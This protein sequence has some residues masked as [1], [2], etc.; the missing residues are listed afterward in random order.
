[1][2]AFDRL[3]Y[4]S[5]VTR[6]VQA[7]NEP[8]EVILI[9]FNRGRPPEPDGKTVVYG[10]V[11][12]T[13]SASDANGLLEASGY[14]GIKWW[15]FPATTA[16]P[17]W[18]NTAFP[19]YSGWTGGGEFSISQGQGGRYTGVID[20]RKLGP[21][22]TTSYKLCII[23]MD[24]AGN[25]SKQ[26]VY[27]TFT[28][29]Q[30][31]D[32]PLI[33]ET[34]L[35]PQE[36]GI[37]GR[38][39]LTIKGTV[40][41]LDLFDQTKLNTVYVQIR[42]PSAVNA[43]GVPTAWPAD[44]PANW[45]KV[46]SE[47]LNPSGDI[48]FTLSVDNTLTGSNLAYFNTDGNK[49]YQIKVT[50]EPV[51][52]AKNYGKN[53]DILWQNNPNYPGFVYDAMPAVSKIFPVSADGLKGYS[54]LLDTK[55][56]AIYYNKYDPTEKI[57]LSNDTV[58]NNANYTT[59]R[60]TFT[61]VTDLI[62][63]L[64]G[65]IIEAH[66]STVTIT[67]GAK[68][69]IIPFTGPVNDSVIGSCYNWD[70]KTAANYTE[71]FSDF[72]PSLDG[73]Q[74]IVIEATDVANN[75]SRVSWNFYKDT[76]GPE[77]GFTNIAMS[78][79]K[80]PGAYGAGG[81]A[82]ASLEKPGKVTPLNTN[83]QSVVSGDN[84][85]NLPV[86]KGTFYDALSFVWKVDS[87]GKP[88]ATTFEYRFKNTS[89]VV[90]SSGWLTGQL[91][92]V[93]AATP[94]EPKNS[95]ANWEIVL[96]S[97]HGFTGPDGENWF[98]IRIMDSAGDYLTGTGNW[99]EIYNVRF[100]VDRF[101]P[102]LT[103]SAD[104][105]V[106]GTSIGTNVKLA[107]EKRV[108]AAAGGASDTV[109]FSVSGEVSDINLTNL[110]I[111][112][113]QDSY[114]SGA[115]LPNYYTVTASWERDINLAGTWVV[116][117]P[118][119]KD[120]I[121]DAVNGTPVADT[122]P[123]RLS[124]TPDNA[125][126]PT[127]WTWKLNILEKDIKNLR[128]TA[129]SNAQNSAR[130]YIKVT[131]QDKAKKRPDPAEQVWQFFLDTRKP[132]I[133]YTTLEKGVNGV[134][135]D[136]NGFALSGTVSDDTGIQDVRYM[137]G[138]WDY[139][140]KDWRW[141]NGTGW[142]LNSSSTVVTTPTSWPSISP[143]TPVNTFN[144]NIN[145]DTLTA[146]G[147]GVFPANLFTNPDQEGKYRLDLY[148]RDW[149]LGNANAGNPHNT[150]ASTDATFSDFGYS[151]TGPVQG[152][153]S[154]RVFYIDR[155]DPKLV[156]DPSVNSQTYFRNIGGQ[157]NLG[158]TTGDTNTIQ[159]WEVVIKD[160]IG[161]VILRNGIGM[162]PADVKG[163][164]PDPGIINTLTTD[165][166]LILKPFMTNDGTSGGTALDMVSGSDGLP[167]TYTVTFTVVDGANKSSSVTKQIILDNRPPVFDNFRP[168]SY[169][170]SSPTAPAAG[171]SYEAYAG[172]F[173]IKGNTTDNSNQL[174][175][176][177]FYVPKAG[178][179]GNT[180]TFNFPNPTTIN[181]ATST[182]D[183]WHWHD[184]N[185]ADSFKINVGTTTVMNIE[186]GTFAWE[187]RIPQTSLFLNDTTV[188]NAGYVQWTKTGGVPLAGGPSVAAQKYR[189]V[190][191]TTWG[192]DG[193]NVPALTFQ[194]LMKEDNPN[195]KTIYGNE[196]VGLITVYI[197]AEDMAGNVTYDALKYWFWPEG[198]RPQ[199]ISINNPDQNKIQAER[200]LNGTIRL[201]GLA[202]DN[203][204]IKYVWFRVLDSNGV[205]YAPGRADKK[206]LH[207]PVWNE[208][209]WEA[210]TPSREQTPVDAG[211]PDANNLTNIG[212]IKTGDPLGTSTGGWY[213]ANGGGSRSVSWWAYVNTQGELD[214]IGLDANEITIE[215]RVQD[216]TWDDSKNN[217]EGGWKDET[218][219]YKGFVSTA[220][221][222]KAWV[223][224]GAPIFEDVK[225]AN[226]SSQD[227]DNPSNTT[228]NWGSIDTTSIRNRSSYRVTVKHNSGISAI[229]WSPTTWNLTLN[230]NAGGFQADPNAE[231]YNLL[232]LANGQ[233][234]YQTSGGAYVTATQADAFTALTGANPTTRMAV[235]VKPRGMIGPGSVT[236]NP[237]KTYLIWKWDEALETCKV[238]THD[239]SH[240]EP[241]TSTHKDMKNTTFK[242]NTTGVSYPANIGTAILIESDPEGAIDYF[243]W[244]VT[245]DV[246]SDV[247][248]S[249]L[250]AKDSNYGKK[251]AQG[252]PLPG[253]EG[254]TINS[255]RYPV[256]LSATEVS[257]ATPLTT[258]A[259]TLLPIDNLPPTAMY[260]LNRRPAG[261]AA[262]IG[263]EAGDDGP[264]A[265]IAKVVLWFSRVNKAGTGR[266]FI[267]WHE[268]TEKDVTTLPAASFTEVP[269]SATDGAGW[270][271]DS[272]VI[273]A[274][275]DAHPGALK[276]V[277]KPYI[278]A[279]G[280]S[281]ATGV[282]ASAIVIDRNSPSVGQDAYGHK[283]PM[284]FADGGMGK[285]WYV[286][287]NTFG[288]ISGPV[289]MHYVVID[290]AG[291]A[292]YYYEPLV[293]MNNAPVINK[294]KLA[295]DIRDN[296]DFRTK[297]TASTPN[298]VGK[299]ST[300]ISPT[301][302]GTETNGRNEI[303]QYIWDRVPLG[304][305]YVQKGITEDIYSS[306]MTVDRIIDF[307]VRNKLLA[308]RIET[309][310]GAGSEKA[311]S[312]RLEYV[313]GAAL[314]SNAALPNMK[315]G[316]VYIINDPGTARWGAIGAEGD[317]PWPRGY[318]FLA[319]VDGT[320][321]EGVARIDGT[322]S[323][324]ELNSSYY[325]TGT[326]V[327]PSA[328][329]LG[330]VAYS[331]VTGGNED[332]TSAE[333][334]YFSGAFG[335]T[336][337]STI[338][339]FN[340]TTDA[341]P[342]AAG[343][344]PTAGTTQTPGAGNS[345]FILR[346][347]DGLET[348]QFGDFKII[349]IRV[350]NDD[351]TKP[352][353]QL[354]DLNP[355]TEGQERA[356]TRQRSLTPMFV[357]EGTNS[358]RTKG[359]LWNTDET[360][361]SISKPGHI[362]PRKM[363]TGY[364]SAATGNMYIT[365]QPGETPGVARNHSLSSEQMGGAKTK[366]AATVQ[367]PWAD[368]AGF[369][370]ETTSNNIRGGDT[371]SG[372]VV[373]RG[374]VE[375]DQR[376][377]QV[378]L[379]IGSSTVTILSYNNNAA[380]NTTPGTAG[381][382]TA[383]ES[384]TYTPPRT[385]LLKIP[386][387][388]PNDQR[389]KVYFTDTIDLYRHRVEW[390]YVW[391]TETIPENTVIA[392]NVNVRVRSSNHHPT[393]GNANKQ[394]DAVAAPGTVHVNTSDATRPN[395][396]PTNPGFPV[397][398]NKYNSINVNLRPYIT[399]FKRDASKFFHNN[400]SMQGWTAFAR[401]EVVV[402]EGFNLGRTA[403]TPAATT[404]I[405]IPGSTNM[406]ANTVTAAQQT[407]YGLAS[408]GVSRYRIFTIGTGATPGTVT[409]NVAAGNN[410]PAVNT[411][412]E[413]PQVSNAFVIQ[414]W[415]I[416]YS[417]GIEGSELWDDTRSVHIW[418][419]N[420]STGNA[421]RGAFQRT[422]G[423]YIMSPSMSID[424]RDGTLHS[425]HNEGGSAA[426]N[427]GSIYVSRNNDNTL[428]RAAAFIDP[429]L[430]SDVYYSV[431]DGT[432][433]NN[434]GAAVWSAF[435]FIGKTGGGET[436]NDYGG[437]WI[438]G[439]NGANPRLNSGLGTTNNYLAESTY[440]NA[441]RN[442]PGIQAN[443]PTT[444]QFMNPHIVT[445]RNNNEEHIHVSYYDTKDGSVKYRYNRRGSAGTIDST[446]AS[447]GWTNLDGGVDEDDQTALAATGPYSAVAANDRIVNYNNSLA[448][449]RTARRD[450]V[451][452][453][454]DVDAGRHNAI[455]LTS[456]GY[457]YV[458][459]FDETNQKL[460]LAVRNSTTPYAARTNNTTN[461][462]II[463]NIIPT[464]NMSHNGTGQFV[465]MKIDTRSGTTQNKIHIA[466]L[467]S[468]NKQLVYISG[469]VNFANG[470][471]GG[472]TNGTGDPVVQVVDSVGM[473][474]RWCALSLDAAGNP[475]ISYQDESNI[476][477]MDGVKMAFLNKT[478]FT[479]AA[480]DI[481]GAEVSG[482]ET[483]HVPA[484]YR[485]ENPIDSG[486][487]H[488]RLGME[489]WPTRNYTGTAARPNGVTD[490]WSGAV[491]YR[492]PDLYR[493]AYYVK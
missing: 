282:G 276:Q 53:P 37:K 158:F 321:E 299:G 360:A 177:A 469:Y 372:Q 103:D 185:Y 453:S 284:G 480:N 44:V 18:N 379:L 77:I 59:Y 75:T 361:R 216:V 149:S 133:E 7:D 164:I 97:A 249:D 347:F 182:T 236:L 423:W 148:V 161:A 481:Y 296:N 240:F 171:Y 220:K 74:N 165:Q 468:V 195:D 445:S 342:P 6:T 187:I 346:V 283:L 21:S 459:Y 263:G 265:G 353:S 362:E 385:G 12:F 248:M 63:A 78:I 370:A 444:D 176:V 129:A 291:N 209:T 461:W 237:A 221:R 318:A 257:K 340:N 440:Y 435:S 174:K 117:S 180:S 91:K 130:R 467:N 406:A 478:K 29:N 439:P 142:T 235:T 102:L 421:D 143:S 152:N 151:I 61:N 255:V 410:Y 157:V 34:S 446:S 483:M 178:P 365:P 317:G 359:G 48:N 65:R 194:D 141:Y 132:D 320:N 344:N 183:G 313:S 232:N 303:L 72:D 332:A 405:S 200:L 153:A 341:W 184:P 277:K 127:K 473:V 402:V 300:V 493:I 376:I 312:F 259:D 14:S 457:P 30:E 443:P 50:D 196:D 238:F 430:F 272:G 281:G 162:L 73:P 5:N 124:L 438:Y 287:I 227:A 375:D 456:Q 189:D 203:E 198:D 275:N 15:V 305:D 58:I 404:T 57:T 324:W 400:R 11:P 118:A 431:G 394:S 388:S 371:V 207:I 96:D 163:N 330:D 202:R 228:V 83:A 28:V 334:V 144:W 60:P 125:S 285:Y 66:L 186:Q 81:A 167:K 22:T 420:N 428:T 87:A 366:A 247:L 160:E 374:Y 306:A 19:A 98:D 293:I 475:W 264:V 487:E 254:Q 396:S 364:G 297:W 326:R 168:Q 308:M 407:N 62:N 470:T 116:T 192:T 452:T 145:Q 244:D 397:G 146:A 206:E 357:G 267:S 84:G 199:V 289:T 64:N 89:G 213:K 315:A 328:L 135:F 191:T 367:K 270:W 343:T 197:K 411:S 417:P 190:N 13:V 268:T 251:D 114:R 369:F 70:V 464:T 261:Q 105:T 121:T 154:G 447:Y 418:Q 139:T 193:P 201:S 24:K 76:T 286:E 51:E 27:E 46:T 322:G 223:V 231:A 250:L 4:R 47:S 226:G 389:G 218:P 86:I 253:R 23:A 92:E 9:D 222:V 393:A 113:G 33:D 337:G 311:R 437:I 210:A 427:S 491:S 71:L 455:A 298:R 140:A 204:R 381:Y 302:S 325:S 358:N 409:L 434:S 333:F 150:M 260:T 425:S 211:T 243:K 355:M 25:Q 69:R 107:P 485:V 179:N 31:K 449:T 49:Y 386:D 403:G 32:K 181:D 301:P 345:M 229:R 384:A 401:E 429:S 290:K 309:V 486:R 279:I 408:T 106:T 269:L 492:S 112:I 38:T 338:V 351:K 390:A 90:T 463:N 262:T 35:D 214:P 80:T 335:N 316:R 327:L 391:D 460:K 99:R 239:T 490:F 42:F 482:W 319:A 245:V 382:G 274:W 280:T 111:T 40:S 136:K 123:L 55:K 16:N 454:A 109:A 339:D 215:V 398:L 2:E 462:K 415:N 350:N 292:T 169:K 426:Y 489:C 354:Y 458:A 115:P 488:G 95:S 392:S 380:Q 93:A 329:N 383:G 17:D 412:S 399:G 88:L 79:N 159:K 273:K 3:G 137:I 166:N 82:G 471:F 356:Q 416:E 278:P 217:N 310:K 258:R 314:L 68:S 474:G 147:T 175:R 349:R 472:N 378:D 422:D 288:I 43:A 363:T 432:T 336:N 256:Y 234:V 377:E 419:S 450:P 368:P 441:G 39:G 230:S 387:Q 252:K 414:P 246:R 477:S 173:N 10:K 451:N 100:I 433:N 348:D 225:V 304:A 479:K 56:P 122:A 436:W 52:G 155:T 134:T 67:Y 20:T 104:F 172:K 94:A 1:V 466:A 119:P 188:R 331:A 233:Y 131:A 465:S 295:T 110:T 448:G 241:G 373:L 41:D 205:P 156:W 8:P 424:P 138:K 442:T 413:R 54:F 85:S 294:I 36:G 307:N 224:A 352:F 128:D 170:Y 242:P 208:E 212:S 108:F 45:I 323:V 101:N 476:G 219:A 266:D 484:Q 126:N 26:I 395:T 271:D 120:M